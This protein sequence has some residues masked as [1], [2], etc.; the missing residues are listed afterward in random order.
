MRTISRL[1]A[2]SASLAASYRHANDKQR[3]HA[4]LAMCLLAVEKTGL[5]SG[6]I[7]AALVLLRREV[8]GPNDL[9]EKLH[10]LAEQLDE[11]YFRLSANN[12]AMTPEASLKFQR[13]RAVAAL[14]LALSPNG[15]QL[16]A[17]IY[18]AIFALSDQEEAAQAAEAIL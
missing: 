10:R 17:A 6:E 4:A 5:H 13:A 14:A 9:Q 12:E 11:E 2:V 1:E 8:S 3:R 18:E 15:E 16:D 7:Q